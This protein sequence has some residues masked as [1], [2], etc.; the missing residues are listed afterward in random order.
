MT[1]SRWRHLGGPLRAERV[2]LS[3]SCGLSVLR[4]GVE[5]ARPWPLALA[6][7]Y[8]LSDG[9]DRP[10]WLA[11]FS[12]TALL[13]GC[14]VGTVVLTAMSG[15]LDM[16]AV[17]SAE[18]AAERIGGHLRTELFDHC[19]QLSPRWH[20]RH[21]SGEVVSRLTSDVG[22]LLDAVVATAAKLV[23]NLLTVVGVLIILLAIHPWLAVLGLS[24]LPVLALAAVKQRKLVHSSQTAAR[25]ASGRLSATTA[26][27]IRNVSTIQ[28]FGRLDRA[29]TDFGRRS[30]DVTGAASGAVEIEARWA[31]RS[32]IV[33]AIGSGLVLIA[34]GLQVRS[35]TI[36]AG[37][38][39]VVIAY[40]KE[41][42]SPIRSLTRLSTVLAKARASIERIADV[43]DADEMV[44]DD[45]HAPLVPVGPLGVAFSA[46]RFGYDPAQP[47]L[48]GFD[49]GVAAGETVCLLGRSGVG[50]STLLLLILRLYD[51]DA[52]C[53]ELGGR[54]LRTYRLQSLRRAIS[55][56]PQDP[57]L[58]DATLAQNV[59]IGNRAATRADVIE[60]CAA[61][62]V[63][64]FSDRLPLGYD[65]NLGEGA[66][67]LSGGQRRRVALARA[68]VS[69]AKLLMLDEPTASLD[70][71]S[72]AEVISAIRGIAADRTTLIVTH[73]PRL[74]ALADR[75]VL[76]SASGTS[77]AAG[78]HPPVDVSSP[79]S[80]SGRR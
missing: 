55:Y 66:S 18:K 52:G 59:A 7:D 1:T 17:Q 32:D 42:Y 14:G 30:A 10:S 65:T 9:V 50:K 6:I 78:R 79:Y 27:L 75:T 69:D 25:T 71:A 70:D 63:D 16:A 35:E 44:P 54:D 11:A 80:L 29:R 15:L 12:P 24:V 72:A 33:L 26:D 53:I 64:E 37:L 21:R 46:V 47:V 40:L 60:A 77:P 41:L 36:T 39:L 56:V 31:P 8:A 61:A 76:V 2:A 43:L 73:D 49:L 58:L 28:A 34:G 20:S 23:P 19:M 13:V 74:A 4:I 51:V 45:P 62:H 38:L 48:N 57:W 68:A 22:R 3:L 5:L 67:R